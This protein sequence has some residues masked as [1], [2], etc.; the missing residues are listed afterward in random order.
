MEENNLRGAP[1]PRFSLDMAPSDFFLSRDIKGKLQGTEF[2]EKD[3]LLVEIRETLNGMPGKVLKAIFIE[4][5]NPVQTCLNQGGEH[6][7]EIIIHAI[8][9]VQ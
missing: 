3:D 1:H 9:H 2:T 5:E 6:L 7:E 8:T 4:W